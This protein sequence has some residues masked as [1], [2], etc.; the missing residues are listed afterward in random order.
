MTCYVVVVLV[1]NHD[2]DDG[3]GRAGAA[4]V[5][6]NLAVRWVRAKS[7]RSQ[8]NWDTQRAL[9]CMRVH[10][11][12]L[13]IGGCR[14]RVTNRPRMTAMATTSGH[15]AAEA[16]KLGSV[17]TIIE[18]IRSG[19]IRKIVTL[20]GAGISVAS[21]I[22]DFRSPGGGMYAT[23]RPEL[24]TATPQQQEAMR[25]NPTLVVDWDLFRIN[26][27]PYL[28]V[29]RSFILG[30]AMHRWQPTLAHVF[31]LLLH[32]KGLLQRHYT[33]NI[34][35]LDHQ[36]SPPLPGDKIVNVHGSLAHVHCE[37]CGHVE[38]M[39][40]FQEKVR[41]QIRNIYDANDS[42]IYFLTVTCCMKSD[43]PLR[44]YVEAPSLST[45][46]DCARCHRPGVKPSTVLFG[47]ELPKQFW[48]SVKED[49]PRNADLLIV[50]GTSLVV[51]P[52]N[53][54]VNRVA[55]K[56]PRLII[57]REVVGE[58]L[59]IDVRESI[60][61]QKGPRRDGF[62]LG[63]CDAMAWHLIDALGWTDDVL[64]HRALLCSASQDLLTRMLASK[65][66]LGQDETH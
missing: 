61:S 37:F 45:S 15:P 29:R 12:S 16:V 46:I 33:Q 31:I 21:G 28:E 2:D 60:T 58:D 7:G 6:G 25:Y 1:R 3:G 5:A 39:A 10:T 4:A 30:T 62:L 44:W 22:P 59:G 32:E 52:A 23:L 40:A 50:L 56:V 34:D 8:R 14:R 35:G 49:F 26:Q 53:A 64:Q 24:L 17:D 55:A 18:K 27:L 66:A 36:L 9:R 48:R 51:A 43:I 19:E 54:L 57:N 42:G 41:T 11:C 63:D 20:S 38:D 65:E 47:R 13:L